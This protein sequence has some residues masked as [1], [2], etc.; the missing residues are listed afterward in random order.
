M[1]NDKQK[2]NRVTTAQQTFINT[3]KEVTYRMDDH[4]VQFQVAST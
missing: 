4:S 3:A 1:D 2:S